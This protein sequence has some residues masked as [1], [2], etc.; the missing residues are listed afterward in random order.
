M[1]CLAPRALGEIVRPRRLSDMGAR[2]LNFTVSCHVDR[3][4]VV[5]TA[6]LALCFAGV[7][8]GLGLHQ[9][10]LTALSVVIGWGLSLVA[11]AIAF[12]LLIILMYRAIW[13]TARPLFNE[14]V[15][16]VGKWGALGWFLGLRESLVVAAN[17]RW[18]GP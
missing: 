7:L 12:V 13:G 14:V 17:N 10:A 3:L 2:P 5:V 4:H 15:A 16:W 1:V 8:V 11:I 9:Q 18:R 6:A